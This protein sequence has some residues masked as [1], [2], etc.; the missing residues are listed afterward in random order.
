MRV[1]PAIER[2]VGSLCPPEWASGNTVFG[3]NRF[4][5]YQKA[6]ELEA[7]NAPV[8]TPHTGLTEPAHCP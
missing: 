7:A 6:V 4:S 1:G 3:K 2:R 5:I 8:S